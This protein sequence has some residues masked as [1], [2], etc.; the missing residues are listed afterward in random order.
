MNSGPEI[1]ALYFWLDAC[2][3]LRNGRFWEVEI[4]AKSI[5]SKLNPDLSLGLRDERL[6][7]IVK[8]CGAVLQKIRTFYSKFVAELRI[9][10][11]GGKAYDLC[12]LIGN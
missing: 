1:P 4:D 6:T 2:F 3:C 11:K 5:H 10:K 9:Q 8:L 7:P 12:R